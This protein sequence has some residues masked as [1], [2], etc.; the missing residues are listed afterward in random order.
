MTD[1]TELLNR[2]AERGDRDALD[3]PALGED[4]AQRVR[5]LWAET[6]PMG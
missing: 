3:L 2:A 6:Y 5:D 1:T 4:A